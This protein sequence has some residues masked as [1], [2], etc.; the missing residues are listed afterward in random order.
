M[1]KIITGTKGT[2]K[3]KILVDKINDAVASSAGLV[4]C[5]EKGMQL[6]YNISHKVRLI[7]A[8]E[9]EIAGYDVLYGFV[10]GILSCNYDITDVFIDGI[11]RVGGRNFD[12]LGAFFERL[13][14]LTG[15]KVNVTAT[16]SADVSTLPVSVT[17]YI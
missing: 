9:Y 17:K 13:D 10:S 1:V 5:V 4:I 15:K 8:D 11:L 12:E 16:V 3:T 7:D 14:K 2:G 6:T